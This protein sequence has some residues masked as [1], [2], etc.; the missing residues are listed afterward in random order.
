MQNLISRAVSNLKIIYSM[1]THIDHGDLEAGKLQ[2]HFQRDLVKEKVQ[3]ESLL[4][5]EDTYYPECLEMELLHGAHSL[6]I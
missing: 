4:M 5:T 1:K 2:E 6:K 3:P